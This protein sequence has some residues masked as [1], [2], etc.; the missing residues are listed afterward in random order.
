MSTNLQTVCV[1]APDSG[2]FRSVGL[3]LANGKAT[4][5]GSGDYRVSWTT[6]EDI[7]RFMGYAF[8]HLTT[9]ELSGKSLRIEGDNLVSNSPHQPTRL[10][11]QL[12]FQTYNE[13]IA[14]YENKTGKKV[15]V[16]RIPKE[17]LLERAAA[18]E[19]FA[20]LYYSLEEYGG[21]VGKPLD[22]DLFLDWN[23]KKVLDVIS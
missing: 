2:S 12:S 18:G 23:P 13:I 8:T 15:E 22:S 3:D 10:P 14:A 1:Q 7:A 20:A 4:I 16:T 9:S 19:M 21:V 5:G 6:R 17:A 11:R